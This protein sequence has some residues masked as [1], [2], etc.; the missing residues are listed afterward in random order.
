MALV[1]AAV[2]SAEATGMAECGDGCACRPSCGNRPTQLGVAV[3]LRVTDSP[4]EAVGS[5]RRR[6]RLSM[7]D[8]FVNTHQNKQSNGSRNICFFS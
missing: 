5:A 1:D 4:A 2:T 8:I 6:G 7:G 3:R